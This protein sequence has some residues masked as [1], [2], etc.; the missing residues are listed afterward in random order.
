[1]TTLLALEPAEVFAMLGVPPDGD[2]RLATCVSTG[3]PLG[4]WGIARRRPPNE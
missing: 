3:Y 2:W 4:R 1:M